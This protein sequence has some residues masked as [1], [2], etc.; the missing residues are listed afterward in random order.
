MILGYRGG[1]WD[2]VDVRDISNEIYKRTHFPVEFCDTVASYVI[3]TYN[4]PS[5]FF[6]SMDNGFHSWKTDVE[7]CLIRS[8]RAYMKVIPHRVKV[9]D[10]LQAMSSQNL[11]LIWNSLFPLQMNL[12]YNKLSA[13]D[14]AEMVYC[15][16]TYRRAM[17]P[18][19]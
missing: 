5:M 1:L 10:K 11:E 15:E 7:R 14:W 3:Q 16:I 18:Q 17:N 2:Y 19:E 12:R 13:T 4:D 6:Y 8:W 9:Q